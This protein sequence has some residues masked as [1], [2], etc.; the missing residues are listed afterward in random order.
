[1]T[2]MLPAGLSKHP[3]P[4]SIWTVM[5]TAVTLRC[6]HFLSNCRGGMYFYF[7]SFMSLCAENLSHILIKFL[8]LTLE[9]IKPP[10]FCI[11]NFIC[12][13]RCLF[14]IQ[15]STMLKPIATESTFFGNVWQSGRKQ[16]GE[17]LAWMA[18]LLPWGQAVSQIGICGSALC[19]SLTVNI[20]I[21]GNSE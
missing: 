20:W 18:A 7:F 1:M 19:I 8:I 12:L 4:A 9:I 15:V 13:L 14:N 21:Q 17:S 16:F 5:L 3:H 11:S 10:V 2:W 6:L